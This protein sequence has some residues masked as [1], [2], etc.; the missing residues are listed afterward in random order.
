MNVVRIRKPYRMGQF[1]IVGNYNAFETL[2]GEAV[3][4]PTEWV[5]SE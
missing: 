5:N 1:G 2:R 3:G 4:T